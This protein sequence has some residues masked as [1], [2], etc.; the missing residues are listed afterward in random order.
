MWNVECGMVKGFDWGFGVE[1]P[2][3]FWERRCVGREA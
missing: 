3:G 2:D 1:Q